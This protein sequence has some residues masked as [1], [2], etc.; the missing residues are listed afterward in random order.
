MDKIELNPEIKKQADKLFKLIEEEVKEKHEDSVAE[1]MEREWG[2]YLKTSKG[3]DML[4]YGK[5]LTLTESE[6]A[7][8]GL[9]EVFRYMNDESAALVSELAHQGLRV[10]EYWGKRKGEDPNNL[11]RLNQW[12]TMLK[13]TAMEID[14]EIGTLWMYRSKAYRN[15]IEELKKA[16]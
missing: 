12:M 9:E 8:Y 14:E 3:F 1:A 4:E 7:I 16:V 11:L 6:Q 2:D 10:A 15:E 5:L 13:E